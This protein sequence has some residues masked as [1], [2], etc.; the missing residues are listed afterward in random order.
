MLTLKEKNTMDSV[1]GARTLKYSRNGKK[2]YIRKEN[3]IDI[4]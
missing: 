2:V 1:G 3:Q 4:L